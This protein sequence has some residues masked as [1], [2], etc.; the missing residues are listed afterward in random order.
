MTQLK[1]FLVCMVVCLLAACASS[2]KAEET[3]ARTEPDP[4]IA[5]Q[6]NT[7]EKLYKQSAAKMAKTL[8]VPSITYEFDSIRPPEEAYPLL[9]KIAT[10]M[11]D[12]P[13]LHL[14]IE[15]HADVVGSEEYNYWLSAS[16]AAAIKSYLVSR[17]IES[18]KIRIHAYGKD[19]PITLDSS[20]EG[21]RANRRVEFTF[22]KRNWNAIY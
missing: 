21:R 16:R 10:V 12:S 18:D 3:P 13:S 17:G 6:A 2:Q 22:T 14:I 8:K 7:N 4:A 11:K 19:R 15:G 5:Q 20:P 9:D 1:S